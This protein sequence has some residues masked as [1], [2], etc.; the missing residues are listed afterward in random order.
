MTPAFHFKILDD[1]IDV[2]NNQGRILCGLLAE[3]CQPFMEESERIV[4]VYPLLTRCT[5]DIICGAFDDFFRF[6][7]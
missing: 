2:Y 1:F 4:D 5:L 7:S 6:P 3:L